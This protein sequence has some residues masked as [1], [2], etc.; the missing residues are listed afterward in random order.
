MVEADRV[1]VGV[2]GFLLLL[3]AAL[4]PADLLGELRE[5]KTGRRLGGVGRET[6]SHS[7]IHSGESELWGRTRVGDRGGYRRTPARF[8]WNPA[9]AAGIS[10]VAACIDA[11]DGGGGEDL[12][13]FLQNFST[14]R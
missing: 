13:K 10:P 7:L 11:R 12:T 1:G 3:L 6:G 2:G 8:P 14:T 4:Q 5:G 9:V